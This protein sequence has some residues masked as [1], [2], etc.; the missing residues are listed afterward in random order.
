MAHGD[1]A[2]GIPAS[3]AVQPIPVVGTPR[4]WEFT[5]HEHFAERAG[6]HFD[7]RLGDGMHA[8]SWALREMP[9]PGE[10]KGAF[11]QPTH[12][13]RYMDFQGV[14]EDGYGKGRVRLAR[15]EK[16][17]VLR[18]GPAEIRFNLYPG[19]DVEEYLLKKTGQG[20][21]ILNTTPSRQTKPNLPSSKP[22]YRVMKADK[23]DP[24]NSNEIWQAKI[25][26]AHVLF[27]FERGGGPVRVYSYRPTERA[28]GL[29]NHTPRLPMFHKRRVPGPLAGSM[30]RGELYA[31]DK[32]GRA[33]P[34][35]RVGGILNAGVWKSRQKQKDEGRI[36]AVVF[37]VVRWKGKDVSSAPYSDK[38]MML[39]EVRR[40]APWLR[41]PRTAMTPASKNQLLADIASGR[42]KSTEEGIIAWQKDKPVPTKVKLQREED[43]H[44]RKIFPEQGSRQL[45]GGFEFSR[46]KNGP[47]VGRVGTGFSHELKRDMLQ[48]PSKYEGLHAKIRTTPAPAHYAPRAPAFAGWHLDQDM[49]EGIKM[50]GVIAGMK[51]AFTTSVADDYRPEMNPL[52]DR[53]PKDPK[54]L[55]IK[56]T[57][58][59]KGLGKVT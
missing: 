49:P 26:G 35:A 25:D 4:K 44:V 41:V 23:T 18:A 11:Q 2:P 20:W 24:A 15:R 28:T 3:R 51:L 47:I 16:A 12:T 30:L 58:T 59:G 10:R 40:H 9:R 6:R 48:N 39:M 27:D 34:A 46:T 7:L 17:E 13:M 19:R 43:V 5:L 32:S 56:V 36:V 54:K 50:A 42:E 52:M 21:I 31:V 33:L 14:I 37:D 38:R 1:F 53:G 8:H 45:A 55:K 22:G 57:P 29:I